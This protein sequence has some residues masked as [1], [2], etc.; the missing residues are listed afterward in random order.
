[1]AFDRV[2]KFGLVAALEWA[3]ATTQTI[4]NARMSFSM[5]NTVAECI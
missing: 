3:G 2:P 5:V 1:M 4:T